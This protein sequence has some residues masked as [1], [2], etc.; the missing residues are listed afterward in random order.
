MI[1]SLS[2]LIVSAIFIATMLFVSALLYD[3]QQV[4]RSMIDSKEEA[5]V[6]KMSIDKATNKLIIDNKSVLDTKII[7]F[8]IIDANGLKSKYDSNTV[9]D[10]YSRVELDF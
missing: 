3:Y 8:Y 10:K 1:S 5:E 6:L 7:K 4:K 2:L 9:V